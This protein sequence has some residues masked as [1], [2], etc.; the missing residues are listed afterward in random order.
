MACKQCQGIESFFDQKEADKDL[1]TYR[2]KGPAATTQ[3]LIDAIATENMDGGSLLDI[4]GGIGALQN[5][6]LKTGIKTAVSVDASTAY[7]RVA[8][9][10]AERQGHADR[11]S[12][13]HGD[14]V[15]AASDIEEA[16]V[17]TLDRVICCYHDVQKLVG[18]SS[19]KAKRVYAVVFPRENLLS[20]I[21]FGV[22]NMYF[23]LR[24]SPFRIFIHPTSVV[25]GL[26]EANGLRRQSHRK[27]RMWQVMVYSRQG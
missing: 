9:Q 17:V 11:I 14:F 1:A 8:E 6:L 25:E 3:M 16:D 10:E 18:L 23:R 2:K 5:E 20:K 22:F 4:G 15:D 12:R 13:H 21:G 26:I 7:A 19:Q 24:R 27:T